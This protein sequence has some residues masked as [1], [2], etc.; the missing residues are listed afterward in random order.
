MSYTIYFS[1]STK[2]SE[3]LIIEDNV[4][5]TGLTSLSF[6]GKNASNYS[7]SISTNFLRLLE[8]FANNTPPPD[9]VEGQLW[10]DTSDATNKKL[11]INDGT[12]V[13]TNWKPINGIYQQDASPDGAGSGDIWVD[14]ARAQLFLTLDGTN[15]TLVG[16]SYSSTLRTGS[17]PEQITDN[18]GNIHSIIKN[19]IDDEVVEIISTDNFTPQIKINGF[20][21]ISAG[22]NLT[23]VNNAQLNATAYAAKNIYVTS[24]TVGYI[25]G[26]NFVRNDISNSINGTLNVKNGSLTIGVDPTFRLEKESSANNIFV[27]AADG[28]KFGFRIIKNEIYN[29]ILTIDGTNQRIGINRLVP[30][31]ALDVVGD[32][33]ITGSLTVTN[34]LVVTNTA[35]FDKRV[36]LSSTASFVSTATFIKGIHLGTGSDSTLISPITMIDPVVDVKY[37]IGTPTKKFASVYAGSFVGNLT[38]QA[39]VA[40]SL[41]N[42]ALF[43]MSGDILSTGFSYAGQ[44]GTY[45]FATTV[46]QSIVSNK[47][48]RTT[49]EGADELLISTKPFLYRLVPAFGGSGAGAAFDVYRDSTTYPVANFT[50]TNTGSGY[51]IGD[52]LTIYGDNL[53]GT[54]P[55]NDIT[56]SVTNVNTLS[57]IVSVGTLVGVPVTGLTRTT[58]D[59]LIGDITGDL[60]PP[61]AMMPYAGLNAPPGWLLCDGA[62]VD[63]VDYPRLFSVIGYRYGLKTTIISKF[64]LPDIKGRM[65]IGYDDMSNGFET[66]TGG[67]GRVP[68]ATSPNLFVTPEE[69]SAASVAGGDDRP[70]PIS[71]VTNF[72]STITG[73]TTEVMNPYLAANYI[74]KY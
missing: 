9:P 31:A 69:D 6:V 35:V 32:V 4:I 68:S 64:R 14:T 54:T 25:S 63:K 41:T 57:N 60:V 59:A 24:P 73:V 16:P 44:S 19:Y 55:A 12:G 45:T 66:S 38:G 30:R 20:S 33:L 58:K 3:A 8:N 28:G 51:E 40:S 17:Y 70:N 7:E 72:G 1:D 49:V 39:T 22:L 42:A 26:N 15:W 11:R 65:V 47:P 46:Q 62:Y 23:T 10:F 61:G 56:V 50:C 13:Q 27:N 5:N 29:E 37:N 53:G 43:N 2:F 18:F 67:A 48:L 36:T 71:T 34:A 74:I 52:V 21:T